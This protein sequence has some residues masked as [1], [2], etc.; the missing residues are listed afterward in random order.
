MWH[1]SGLIR[2]VTVLEYISWSLVIS[3]RCEEVAWETKDKMY[4]SK[5]N[6]LLSSLHYGYVLA[7]QNI[8]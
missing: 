4:T 3:K 7:S 2:L 8:A 1:C 5:E 6:C